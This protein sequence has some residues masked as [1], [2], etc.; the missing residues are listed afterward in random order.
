MRKRLPILLFIIITALTSCSF[1]INTESESGKYIATLVSN[2]E[3]S[4]TLAS[5]HDVSQNE[6]TSRALNSNYT[7]TAQIG[8]D[9]VPVL[10]YMDN[11]KLVSLSVSYAVCFDNY[12]ICDVE[13]VISFP[14]EIS[15]D[16][17]KNYVSGTYINCT[18]VERS[19]SDRILIDTKTRKVVSIKHLM[20]TN[21]RIGFDDNYIY[22]SNGRIA[23]I[24]KNN[25]N[26]AIYITPDFERAGIFIVSGDFIIATNNKA[27]LKD[28]SDRASTVN[29]TEPP[30]LATY[31]V[32]NDLSNKYIFE[33]GYYISGDK[34]YYIDKISTGRDSVGE[35]L[36]R[37]EFAQIDYISDIRWFTADIPGIL[38]PYAQSVSY[39][40]A[41]Y[42]QFTENEI[43]IAGNVLYSI[44]EGICVY[45]IENPELESGVQ[46]KI[47]NID[48]SIMTT[49]R[50]SLYLYEDN[51]NLYFLDV[52]GH[53]IHIDL[54]TGIYEKSDYIINLEET[55]EEWFSISDTIMLYK[56]MITG[57]TY[58]TKRLDITDLH[59]DPII[60]DYE[61]S[62]IIA[63]P[64]FRL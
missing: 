7:L 48:Y 17:I 8:L 2:I 61:S 42:D 25:L 32:P 56:E 33:V 38:K 50:D 1:T 29:F 15:P 21:S 37:Q 35:I 55:S 47:N 12:I 60:V 13:G 41:Y 34:F 11:N 23:K 4:M 57:S 22:L 26:Q 31:L 62:D 39:K 3:G 53:I 36:N 59:S 46:C 52:E 64:N 30:Y 20:S 10:F 16:N 27:Y 40:G 28:D 6:S 58:V 54:L 44:D 49:V 19:F 24:S 18:I 63:V 5:L 45:F 51:E 43:G 14:S 9:Y